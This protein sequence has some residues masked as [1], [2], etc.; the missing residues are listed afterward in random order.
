MLVFDEVIS[1]PHEAT[2]N[3]DLVLYTMELGYNVKEQM[4]LETKFLDGEGEEEWNETPMCTITFLPSEST[5]V[6]DVIELIP[7][8]LL[9]ERGI[10]SHS[11]YETKVKFLTGCPS[12]H[13]WLLIPING[14]T[15][16]LTVSFPW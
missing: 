7:P 16:P 9:T 15:Q 4:A 13:G 12:H 11:D 6:N 1:I 10:S 2:E 5:L 3:F 8:N 14:A